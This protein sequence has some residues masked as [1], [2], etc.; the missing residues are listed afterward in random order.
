MK[1][2][3]R[4]LCV[5][6][7]AIAAFAASCATSPA[8]KSLDDESREFLSKV[9]YL[10]TRQERKQFLA[11]PATE[12]KAFRDEFWEKRVVWP[13]TDA[14][15]FKDQYFARIAEA[16]HLFT[17][18]AEP[19]WLQDRGRVYILLGPPTN[20][21]TYPRGITFYGVPT[22]IW[23][24]GFFPVVFTDEWWNGN[25]KLHP[26]NVEQLSILNRTQKEWQ[27]QI[28]VE[29]GKINF[30]VMVK[31]I[32]AG[33]AL[34]EVAIPFRTIWFD[35][36]DKTLRATLILT[37][38]LMEMDEKEI[39]QSRVEY[40][41]EMTE[42]KFRESYDKNHVIEV[43]VEA[44]EGDYWLRLTLENAND[45]SKASRRIRLSI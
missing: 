22:E 28:E 41:L 15:E 20:R 36:K 2:P 1:V 25:Y 19:G 3:E 32:L 26:E 18:A 10:I 24:Y 33:R 31:E 21:I 42:D 35:V 44:Q 30:R 40:P 6:V 9:R 45:G 13:I 14:G 29:E 16:N 38:V 7:L 11:I 12:R 4:H 34:I 5:F 23:Y 27:P 17:E 8:V 37:L 43:P 39:W